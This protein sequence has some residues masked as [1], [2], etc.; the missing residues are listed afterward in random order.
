MCD[1]NEAR[2]RHMRNLYSDVEGMTDFDHLLNGV[3]LDAVVVAAPVRHHYS[4][5]K[6]SL[7]AG[8][9]TFDR[10]TDGLLLGR[11][12]RELI[13]IAETQR[14]GLDG[15]SHFSSISAPVR[16]IA[17][18]VQAGDIGE[19]RY[20]NSRRLNLGLFQKDINVAW[21]PGSA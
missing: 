10:E 4:L 1:L 6:A 5:A 9:H 7:L 12:A 19:I 15:G 2:L 8:K 11:S 3:G 17:E 21:G 16:K 13:E 20:I 18:I 14:L